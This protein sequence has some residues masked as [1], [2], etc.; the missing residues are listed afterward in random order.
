MREYSMHAIHACKVSFN[1][2]DEKL[3]PMISRF[4]CQFPL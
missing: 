1:F 2:A 4:F 3:R